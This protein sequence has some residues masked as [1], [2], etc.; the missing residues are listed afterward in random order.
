MPDVD[1]L[2]STWICAAPAAV[3]AVVADSRNWR[4]WWPRLHLEVDERRGDQG[5]R[6]WVRPSENHSLEGSMEVWLEPA[7]DG[8][9]AHYFLRLDAVAGRSVSA[10]RARGVARRYGTGAKA[11]FWAIGDR[12]DPGRLDRVAAPRG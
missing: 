3:A 5:M 10:R 12:L 1:V 11:V 4:R 7:A 6:W 9:V 2:D 8:V